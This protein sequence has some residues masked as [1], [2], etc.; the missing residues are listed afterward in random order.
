MPNPQTAISRDGT[1]I[2]FWRS[3]SG[4][5]VLLV[6][7]TCED[8][9]CW[10]LVRPFLADQFSTHTV[11]RRGRE[12]SPSRGA[13][14]LQREF[15]H[16]AAVVEAIGGPVHVFGHSAGAL[17]SIGAATLTDRIRSL[18]LYEPRMPPS[19]HVRGAQ[20]LRGVLE[21]A[22]AADAVLAFFRAGPGGSDE[23]LERLEESTAWPSIV[24]Q[25]RS[26]PDELDAIGHYAFKAEHFEELELPVL[27]LVGERSPEPLRAVTD[28]LLPVL[29]NARARELP[30]QQHMANILAPDLL[31]SVATE[32]LGRA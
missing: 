26:I 2:A 17:C 28:A 15:E 29:S 6:H 18:V 16:I 14:E 12:G 7:G 22:S 4:P 30:G 25:A 32:F 10:Q 8:R 20:L 23:E 9:A 11:N 13:Y 5:A 1:E 3:V 27:F 24:A 19:I 21:K 31:A